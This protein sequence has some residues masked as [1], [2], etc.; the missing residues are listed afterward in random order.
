MNVNDL[1]NKISIITG[2]A[3]LLGIQHAHALL[4]LNSTVILIDINYKNY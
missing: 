1:K 4:E 3:G 2:G